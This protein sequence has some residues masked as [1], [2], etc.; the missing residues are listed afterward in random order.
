MKNSKDTMRVVGIVLLGLFVLIV[1][2]RLLLAA[3]GVTLS[4]LGVVTILA[5][6]LIKLA[7]VLAVVYLALVGVRT[8]LR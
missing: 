2:G 8:L 3:A 1:G 6:G 4:I 5:V 7:V